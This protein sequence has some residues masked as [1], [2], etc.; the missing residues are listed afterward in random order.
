MYIITQP[1]I[2]RPELN[3]PNIKYFNPDSADPSYDLFN[4]ANIYKDKDIVS[5]DKY[6]INK[7]LDETNKNIPKI[8]KRYKT[9]YSKSKDLSL[10]I[11]ISNIPNIV[12]IAFIKLLNPSTDKKPTSIVLFI[13][14]N[15]D[16][17]RN[18]QIIKVIIAKLLIDLS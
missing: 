12:I 1:A 13:I 9:I 3:A 18:K 14:E 6:I 15:W 4:A 10:D 7:S 17:I 5:I 2:K 11:R 8:D 16:N